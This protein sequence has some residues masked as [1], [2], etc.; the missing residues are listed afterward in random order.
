MPLIRIK[1]KRMR[2]HSKSYERLLKWHRGLAYFGES[3]VWCS[4]SC[5]A[6]FLTG[7]FSVRQAWETVS[8]R[9][10]FT[11]P[12]QPHQCL[13]YN[14]FMSENI[15]P[16]TDAL[17][18]LACSGVYQ[19]QGSSPLASFC[20]NKNNLKETVPQYVRYDT[21]FSSIAKVCFATF[22]PLNMF[23]KLITVFYEFCLLFL[24]HSELQLQKC[25]L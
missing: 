18:F 1:L 22:D 4:C 12:L 3:G 24:K 9:S 14:Q 2:S 19:P 8:I 23:L 16:S 25:L 13:Q 5:A 11:T 15:R 21:L 17:I 10:C 20:I 6:R 7:K